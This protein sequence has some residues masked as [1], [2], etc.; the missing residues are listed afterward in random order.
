MPLGIY[1]QII[2]SIGRYRLLRLKI[3]FVFEGL[4]LSVRIVQNEKSDRVSL[5]TKGHD[6]LRD[7]TL[8]ILVLFSS[9]GIGYP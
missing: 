2:F 1:S 9:R 4:W 8:K 3:L 6:F 7:L 5:L